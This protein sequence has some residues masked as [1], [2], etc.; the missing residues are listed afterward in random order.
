MKTH[1]NTGKYIYTY[2]CV[3]KHYVNIYTRDYVNIQTYIHTYAE[4]LIVT[5]Q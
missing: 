4:V 1:V 3:Y 2:I 5:L